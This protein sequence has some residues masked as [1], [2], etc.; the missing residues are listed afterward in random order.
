MFPC[1]M[2]LRQESSSTSTARNCNSR[3][4][5]NAVTTFRRRGREQ[6]LGRDDGT[7]KRPF[8]GGRRRP[9]TA[10]GSRC[11]RLMAS[12]EQLVPIRSGSGAW[13]NGSQR[14]AE[15]AS[16]ALQP[17]RPA[18]ENEADRV[19]S[20]RN[21]P[22]RRYKMK[23]RQRIRARNERPALAPPSAVDQRLQSRQQLRHRIPFRLPASDDARDVGDVRSRPP[24]GR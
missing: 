3:H 12:L 15:G 19:D 16:S 23:A 20:L 21:L 13:T 2:R 5:R 17:G 9:A 8:Q 18:R 6:R 11:G 14:R 7:E 1:R 22:G 24:A 10:R 4:A